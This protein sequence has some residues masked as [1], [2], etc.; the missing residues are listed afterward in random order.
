MNMIINIGAFAIL[1]L[2]WVGFAAALIFNQ[3]L[4]DTAWQMLRGLPGCGLV[5]YPAGGSR[6]VDLGN[7]LA[8]LAAS[9]IGHWFGMGND[10]YLLPSQGISLR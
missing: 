5:A 3:T 4:L 8:A 9:C 7:L 2:L 6:V 1:T 10:L